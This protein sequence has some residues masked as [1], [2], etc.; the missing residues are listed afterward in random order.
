M[1][2][3]HD[4]CLFCREDGGRVLFRD[5]RLR[6]I[7]VD[8]ADYPG[9]LRVVWGTHVPEM[10]DLA[11]ADRAHC[12]RAVFAAETALREVAR[13]Y[14]VNLA[15]FGNVVPHIHWHVIPRHRDDVHWPAPVW[16]QRQRD[17]RHPLAAGA[18]EEMAGRVR[19]LMG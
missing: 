10:T 5:D 14:K 3:T 2:T 15:A 6:V 16:G 18:V 12:M 4:D 1:T 13:P 19:G 9:F 17:M 8:D 11:E 7:L